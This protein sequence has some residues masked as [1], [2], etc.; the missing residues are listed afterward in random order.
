MK[1]KEVKLLRESS[2]KGNN[3]LTTEEIDDKSDVKIIF[4]EYITFDIYLTSYGRPY[5]GL[6]EITLSSDYNIDKSGLTQYTTSTDYLTNVANQPLTPK[7]RIE[8]LIRDSKD[9]A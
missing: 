3:N 1:N 6:K 7:E 9:F 2:C 4:E 5:N 8:N